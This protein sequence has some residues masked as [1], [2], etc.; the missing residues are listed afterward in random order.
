MSGAGPVGEAG[1]TART[2]IDRLSTSPLVLG[3]VVVNLALCGLLY[4]QAV[5]GERERGRELDLLY[6]NRTEVGQL[7]LQCKDGSVP[8]PK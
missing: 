4:W 1:E 5:I 6:K 2:L 3:L 7:L 8:Q